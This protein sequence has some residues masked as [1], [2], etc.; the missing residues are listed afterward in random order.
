MA[1]LYQ[2]GFELNSTASDMEWTTV[3]RAT[4]TTSNARTGTYSGNLSSAG[5][6]A[7]FFQYQFDSSNVQRVLY[8][9]AYMYLTSWPNSSSTTI[10]V[11]E[12][13]SGTRKLS[14][15]A[16]ASN[17]KFKLYNEEDGSQVGSDS[18]TLSL[19]TYYRFELKIDTTTLASTAVEAKIDGTTFASGTI[20][21]ASG[22]SFFRLGSYGGDSGLTGL[23]YDDIALN[24]GTGS[25]QNSYPGSGKVIHLRPS[26]AGDSNGFLAQI[27]G[28]VGSANN[29]TRVNEVTP[30][31]AT[32]Y[33]GSALLNAEDLFNAD[34]SGIGSSDSV[35]VVAV[36]VRMADL[37][38]TDST[39]A[40][41]VELEKTASGT[42]SQSA[43]IAPNST[44]WLTNSAASPR[45]YPLVTYQDPDAADWAKTTL[46]SMQIGYIQTA[47]NVRTIAVS[48]L[49]AS[50]DYTPSTTLNVN[51]SDS[52]VTSESILS[53]IVE[54]P[55]VSDSITTTESLSH[56]SDQLDLMELTKLM[57]ASFVSRSD[58]ITITESSSIVSSNRVSVV[59]NITLTEQVNITI[60]VSVQTSDS[61]TLSESKVV[62][63]QFGVQVIPGIQQIQ[64]VR[65][66]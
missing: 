15:Q 32:S 47:T 62:D 57:V 40:F 27:G 52:M 26:A 46:D 38:A 16:G 22:V 41:K 60:Q 55:S 14:I 5:A 2:S 23:Y 36:G 30:D 53:I 44:A 18:S 17:G 12:S 8:L 31:D 6:G 29:Y 50:V 63:I 66:V 4:V 25:F 59:E 61:T 51:V 43:A 13:A 9:R 45:N 64:G 58:N 28:T 3:S 7:A 1:R 56:Y 24:D 21:L 35:N 39:A 48:T 33:N 49:W 11:F 54:I 19:N 34:D 37:V 10:M 20:D 65:I 42:K